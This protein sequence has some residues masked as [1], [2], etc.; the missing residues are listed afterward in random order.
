MK[1]DHIA[2]VCNDI[3]V[4]IKW[5]LNIFKEAKILYQDDTWGL[6]GTNTWKIAFVSK[7]QHP[8]HI[9]FCVDGLEDEIKKLFPNK[10]WK[11][12]RDNSKSIYIEDPDSNYIEFIKYKEK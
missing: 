6:I 5:Y 12:H 2:M 7:S 1:L 9:A 4:S 3:D 8:Q 10:K 11:L